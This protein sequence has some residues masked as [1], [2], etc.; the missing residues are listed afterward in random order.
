L[1]HEILTLDQKMNLVSNMDK[2]LFMKLPIDEVINKYLD[3]NLYLPVESEK[4]LKKYKIGF[5]V[6]S[7]IKKTA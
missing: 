5:D 6:S 7:S 2:K 3:N 4:F 1:I